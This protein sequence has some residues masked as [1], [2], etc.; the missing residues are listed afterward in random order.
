MD[1]EAQKT[2]KPVEP[3]VSDRAPAENAYS[4]RGG[5]GNWY[6]PK[7]VRA[8]TSE[9]STVF[10]SAAP[11]KPAFQGRGGAGNYNDE[12]AE[13]RLQEQKAA[14]EAKRWE[15]EAI[16]M[17]DIGLR[18]PEKAYLATERAELGE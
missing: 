9:P 4:G 3:I 6:S 13:K 18:P 11:V 7:E 16:E 2:S 1:L 17:V 10:K 5:A 14:E 8:T 12:E 15:Q